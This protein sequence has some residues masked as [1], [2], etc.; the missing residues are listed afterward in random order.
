VLLTLR[1]EALFGGVGRVKWLLW[2]TFTIFQG[3]R[4]GLLLFGG[5][6]IYSELTVKQR[7]SKLTSHY[8]V[9]IQ[10]SPKSDLCIVGSMKYRLTGLLGVPTIFDLLL[11]ILTALKAI[12]TPISM[13]KD[14]IV[15]TKLY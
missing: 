8:A 5:A 12:R 2:I 7:I 9:G 4:S 3:M 15:C 14:S 11:L 13:K 6:V 1:V 10:Y